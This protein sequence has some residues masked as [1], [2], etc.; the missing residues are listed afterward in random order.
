MLVKGSDMNC[1]Q[2]E[3]EHADDARFCSHCGATLVAS[4]PTEGERKLVTVLFADVI[5]ST[6]LGELLDPEQISEIMNGAFAQF[7]RA[8]SRYGGTVARL[9]GDAVLAIFGAPVAHEDDPVRAVLAGLAIQEAAEQYARSVAESY[10]IEFGVRVGINTGLAVLTTVGDESR[11]EY[12]AMGDT[13]NVAARMQTAATPGTVLMSGETHHFVNRVFDVTPRGPLEVKGKSAPINA[14]EIVG[15]RSLPARIRGLEGITSALVGRD[16]ELKSLRNGLD[17]TLDG[18]GAFVAIDGEAGLGKSRLI[19][20]LGSIAAGMSPRIMWLEGRAISYGQTL[21]Y[22]PWRQ[23]L[24]GAIGAH[25]TTPAEA[26]RESL[27]REWVKHRLPEETLLFL[28]ALLGVESEATSASVA[29]L[30]RVEITQGITDAVRAYLSAQAEATPLVLVFD[31]LHWADEA[32][33][34]LLSAAAELVVHHPIMLVA[35]VRPDRMAA[36]WGAL[37]RIQRRLGGRFSLIDLEPLSATNSQALLGNLL[38]IEEVPETIRALIL[39]KSEGNPFFLEEIIRSLIDSDYLIREDGHWRAT[40]EIVDVAIPDTLLGLLTA[41]IDRLPALTKQV[42]QIA[43]VIGRT[44]PYD[45]LTA[46]FDLAPPAERIDDPQMHLDRLAME[47]LVREW[48]RDPRLEY[49]FKHALT[50]EAAYDLLLMRRRREYHCRVGIV[51]ED[52]YPQRLDEL[53]PLIEHHFWLGEDW[54]HAAQYADRAGAEA[55]RAG[56]L[57]EASDHYDRAYIALKKTPDRDPGAVVDAILAWARTSYKLVPSDTVL[58]RLTEAEVTARTIH[59]QRRLAHTLNWIGNVHFYLGV[60]SAGIPALAEGD[61]LA[62]ELGEEGLVLAWTFIMTESLTDQNPRAALAQ[63][64]HVIELARRNHFE[65]IEAHTIGMKAM[66]HGRLGEFVEAEEALE[67]ALDLVRRINSPVKEADVLAAGAH[68]Y[69]DM[70][71][72]QRGLECTRLGVQ[73]AFS[74]DGYECG[75]YS[76]YCGGMGQLQHGSWAEAEAALEDSARR[77][78]SSKIFSE[79]LKNRIRAGLAMTRAHVADPSAV[80]EM[81]ET[82]TRAQAFEDDYMAA[83][84][85]HSL[86]ASAMQRGDVERARPYLDAALDYYR[87]NG[88]L[89]YLPGILTSIADLYTQEGQAQRATAAR[90]EAQRI[91]SELRTQSMMFGRESRPA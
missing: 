52:L 50:Q 48:V 58:E 69:F 82:L 24:R 60:P 19:A 87:R 65:D 62:K 47:E 76:L 59:D 54:P 78:E 90:L 36:S 32:S 83:L 7:N 21:P 17:A 73:L 55:E 8:V 26:T 20:E 61:R 49:I 68:M 74:V 2:C 46:V 91:T 25:D 71:D 23:M 41:R 30:Q 44:F 77:A 33:L 57:H 4:R 84:L 3:T 79:W 14:Y 42:V 88:M 51:L 31:D 63:I 37:Q 16:A 85:S 43:A 86:G 81:E 80:G 22:Y 35:I 6:A 11:T 34:E 13:V 39:R 38:Y 10:G 27:R 75:I 1:P 45:V 15:L 12:T 67:R 5:G 29:D 72:V 18:R 56:A 53:A 66:T 70:G 64:D 89:P 28:E 9:L 40:R